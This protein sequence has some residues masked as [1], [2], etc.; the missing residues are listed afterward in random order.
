MLTAYLFDERRGKRV[1]DWAD[2]VGKLG[3]NQVLWVDLVDPSEDDE[4]AALE[5]GS[6][7]ATCKLPG[8]RR[9]SATRAANWP[10]TTSE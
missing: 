1:E 7:W 6:S 8:R 9:R 2:V 5:T 3:E 10:R 4:R